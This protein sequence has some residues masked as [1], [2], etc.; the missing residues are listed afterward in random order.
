MTTIR[1]LIN[2][3]LRLLN[4]IQ[5]NENATADDMDISLYALQALIDSWSTDKLSIFKIRQYYFPLV[6][7]QKEYTIGP[8]GDFDIPRP[9][10]IEV[11]TVTYGGSV[12]FN[13]STGLYELAQTPN[14]QDIP[15]EVLTMEQYAAVAVKNQPATYPTKVYDNGNFPLRTLSF[16]PVPT[17]AQPIT[18][19]VW[20]PLVDPETL[21]DEVN[22]PKGYER[23]L[24]YNL[25][26]ELAAEFGKQVPDQVLEIAATSYGSLK[27]LNSRNQVMRSDIALTK[28]QTIYNWNLSVSIPN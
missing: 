2:G 17:T 6:A 10:N 4:V 1:K 12:T 13:E 14:I 25:A 28:G 24:R 19:W 3:S 9:M 18:L 8:G 23:A 21:D 11:A 5:A 26:V 27:R 7:N 15:I 20:Q 16:W 22:F